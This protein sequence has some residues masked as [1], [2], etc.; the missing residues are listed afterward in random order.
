MTTQEQ[1]VERLK[2]MVVAKYGHAILSSEDCI[3]LAETVCEAT[4]TNLDHRSLELMFVAKRHRHAPRPAVLSTLASYVG[5]SSWSNFCSSRD[6]LPAD[7]TDIIPI[8]RRWGVIILTIVAILLVVSTAL[9]LLVGD[10]GDEAS[11]PELNNL[12]HD[13]EAYYAAI[14][15]E[16]S[17]ELRRYSNTADYDELISTLL[18]EGEARINSEIGGYIRYEAKELGIT[19][20]DDII[21][22][23]HQS[24]IAHYRSVYRCLQEE[25]VINK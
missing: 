2:E 20:S 19:V 4:S 25:L 3:H 14:A 16:E 24:V 5:Y 11:Q 7:D 22:E 6:V 17:I 23:I 15:T 13:V 10:I 8:K 9:F 21:D 12:R 18:A 1:Y